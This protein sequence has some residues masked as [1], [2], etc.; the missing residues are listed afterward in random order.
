MLSGVLEKKINPAKFPRDYNYIIMP[1]D[2]YQE[3]SKEIPY[4]VGV[5][6]SSG[7]ELE[8][9]QKGMTVQDRFLKCRCSVRRQEKGGE[10]DYIL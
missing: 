6:T 8:C 3:V 7:C 9:T 2:M 10:D 5:Y 4:Y 1:E